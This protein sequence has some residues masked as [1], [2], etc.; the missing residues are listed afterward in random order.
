M[1]STFTQERM[2]GIGGSDAAP[3]CGMSRFKTPLQVYLEK[4]GLAEDTAP[5]E[6]MELG[7]RLEPEIMKLYAEKMK[8][9][10]YKPENLFRHSV[11]PFII[12]HLDGI[13]DAN[14]DGKYGLECKLTRGMPATEWGESGTDE[15]PEPYI[16]Q[17]QHYM[18]V[19]GLNRFDIAALIGGT[20]FRIYHIM[21]NDA[22]IDYMIK[23]E[24]AFWNNHVLAGIPPEI[25]GSEAATKW[26][27]KQFPSD[28]GAELVADEH[29]TFLAEQYKIAKENAEKLGER[30]QEFRNQIL[31][32]LGTAATIKGE[33]F[34][35]TYK[36]TKD[37]VDYD[38]KA[39]ADTLLDKLPDAE[40]NS[41]LQQFTKIKPGYRR[42]LATYKETE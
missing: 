24:A 17:C 23:L 16:L 42:F 12:G 26:L 37:G 29:L 19:T 34:K 36:K 11:H 15:V 25:D 1:T 38:W 33:N 5:S 18:A 2:T 3:V 32:I 8:V 30:A 35:I 41:L 40:A 10:V 31:H 39:L 9:L 14:G 6:A 28:D 22:L 7:N 4:K 27:K 20:E 13:V 21:R